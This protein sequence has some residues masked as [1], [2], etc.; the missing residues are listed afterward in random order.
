[1]IAPIALELNILDSNII[2][3][4]IL[5]NE[6]GSYAGFDWNKPTSRNMGKPAVVQKVKDTN[7]YEMVVMAGDGASN[8][9][10][11]PPADAFVG[12]GYVAVRDKARSVACW[13]V[14][15]FLGMTSVVERFGKGR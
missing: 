2:A 9:Q 5:H 6:D 12:Y 4:T 1:M 13:Y 10:A 15:D 7:G 14:R 11:K 3:N 8:S